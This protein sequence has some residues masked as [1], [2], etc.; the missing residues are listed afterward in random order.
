M[1]HDLSHACFEIMLPEAKPH[2]TGH[3]Y[4]ERQMIEYVVASGWLDGRL[5]A[6]ARPAKP[7]PDVRTVRYERVLA[8]I[9]RWRSKAKRADTALKKLE[10][11]RRYYERQIAAT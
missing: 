3:A 1:V 7:K 5:Q 11:Q 6:K 9:R 4:I 10:R 2:A 8:G